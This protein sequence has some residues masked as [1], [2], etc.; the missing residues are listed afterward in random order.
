MCIA[1]VPH[2]LYSLQFYIVQRPSM[3][4]WTILLKCAIY[5]SKSLFVPCYHSLLWKDPVTVDFWRDTI[6]TP[7]MLDKLWIVYSKIMLGH[8]LKIIFNHRWPNSP[9][10]IF[11]GKKGLR[12]VLLKEEST[13]RKRWDGQMPSSLL[14]VNFYFFRS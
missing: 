7:A 6:Y 12:C 9:A 5:Y 8:Y 10:F 2:R 14:E 3:S 1:K 4:V 13:M 11:T